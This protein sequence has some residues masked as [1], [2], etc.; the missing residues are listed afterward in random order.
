MLGNVTNDV[1]ISYVTP[2]HWRRLRRP[3]F[4]LPNISSNEDEIVI[5]SQDLRKYS[6]NV[7]SQ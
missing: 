3:L 2:P 5:K 1:V 6:G 4:F 7:E